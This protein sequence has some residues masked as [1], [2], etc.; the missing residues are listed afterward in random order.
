[1]MHDHPIALGEVD[2][3]PPSDMVFLPVRSTD[4]PLRG[5]GDLLDW[6]L[7]GRLADAQHSGFFRGELG[8]V[9]CVLGLPKIPFRSVCLVGL[10]ESPSAAHFEHALTEIRARCGSLRLT[11]AH[12][13]FSRCESATVL[14]PTSVA[15]SDAAT[16]AM[17]QWL[18][19]DTTA[20]LP[21]SFS[22]HIWRSV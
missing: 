9:C 22:W 18:F 20:V 19:G 21:R 8:E 14:A 13:D 17:E 4:T 1:M 5:L 7:G 10:G 16:R 15:E 6:R 12:I 2:R 3:A 11:S